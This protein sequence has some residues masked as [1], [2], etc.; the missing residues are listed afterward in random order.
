M[1]HSHAV[2]TVTLL[3]SLAGCAA[4]PPASQEN[5]CKIFDEYPSWYDHARASEKRWQTPIPV[6]VAIIRQESSFRHNVKPPRD[7]L[8]GF[9]PLPRKSSAYGY[10]QAQDPAWSD[11]RDATGRRFARRSSIADA[12]D[13]V[14]WYNDT[15]HR[16][17]G[18][19]KADAERLYLAYHEGHGGY[20]RGS[21]RGKAGLR[22]T[23]RRVDR[24]AR[25]F[26]EQL[27][28]CEDRF[29]CRRFWQVWPFCR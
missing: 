22:A 8:L 16:R 15:S 1:R 3:A 19:A 2:W 4:T 12:L 14:G 25:I 13:F 11:Y 24:Q 23:A 5:I 21:Y 18:I 9:I 27:S 17:L 29:R 28:T 6:Q 10:A 7:R 20:S 26:T